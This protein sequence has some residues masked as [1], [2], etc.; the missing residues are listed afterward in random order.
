MPASILASDSDL[1][2]EIMLTTV[3]TVCWFAS[4]LVA[5]MYK[6]ILFALYQRKV[7]L[8]RTLNM[9]RSRQGLLVIKQNTRL[10]KTLFFYILVQVVLTLPLYTCLVLAMQCTWC[11]QL[12]MM[13]FCLYAIPGGMCMPVIHVFHWLFLTPQYYREIKRLAQ[14]MFNCVRRKTGN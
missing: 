6:K 3:I 4:I 14:K 10:A 8:R 12:V 9:T 5:L 2:A 7:T 11:N 1:Y 13:K